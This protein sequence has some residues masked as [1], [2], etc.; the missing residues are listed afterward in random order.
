MYYSQLTCKV[1]G[2][3]PLDWRKSTPLDIT[4][5]QSEILYDNVVK[6]LSTKAPSL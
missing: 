6:L 4:G 5:S 1:V 3:G 2:S